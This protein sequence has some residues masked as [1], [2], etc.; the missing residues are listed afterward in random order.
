MLNIDDVKNNIQE[1]AYKYN[2]VQEIDIEKIENSIS[3]DRKD[4]FNIDDKNFVS[5]YINKHTNDEIIQFG[6]IEIVIDSIDEEEFFSIEKNDYFLI[7]I[8]D[9]ST[10]DELTEEFIKQCKKYQLI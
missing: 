10:I 2:F 8:H 3:F 9:F 7:N 5:L 6:K 4:Y 1:F